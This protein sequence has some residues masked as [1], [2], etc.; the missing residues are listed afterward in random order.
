MAYGSLLASNMD[1]PLDRKSRGAFFTPRFLAE[2][3]AAWT[4]RSE[5]ERVLEPACGEAEFMLAALDRLVF[6]GANPE[7]AER[8]VDGVELH[9]ESACAA[10]RRLALSRYN[11]CVEVGDFLDRDAV[12]EYDAVIGNPPYIRF[13]AI[14]EAQRASIKRVSAR[15]GVK[16]SA[17][18][19]T[20]APFV[21]QSA[22]CLKKG[23]RLGL[24]LPA[25]LLSVNY[26]ASIRSFLLGSFSSIQLVTFD[27]LVFPEVQEEVVVL[28]ADGYRLG[29][30]DVIKWRQ[31]SDLT[32]LDLSSLVDYVPR[33]PED[34]WSGLF[35]SGN[36]LGYLQGLLDDGLFVPLEAWGRISLGVV[37]G[38]NGFFALS[39][40]QVSSYNL[41]EGDLVSL[42]PP[43]SRHLRRFDFSADDYDR[44]RRDNEKTKLFY[45]R[46]G[47]LSSTA[48]SYVETG[49]L[50][51]VH[52]A[53]KCRKR[54]PWWRVPVGKIPDAFVTYMN[55]YGPNICANSAGVIALNSCHGLF[56]SGESAGLGRELLPLACMNSATLFGSEIVG[57]SYGGGMLKLEP[58]EACRLPVPSLA[59]VA[60][61]A[62]KLRA[63]RPY[64]SQLMLRRDYD[65]V[66]GLVDA[67]L[68]SCLEGERGFAQMAS[69]CTM[70]RLRRKRRGGG[71]RDG[72]A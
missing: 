49:E 7:S 33:S 65:A 2:F 66:V 24:V 48:E 40:E 5:S 62:D 59:V 8:C 20:W 31:C 14:G 22:L 36:A 12:G 60:A 45:P 19:S 30:A 16:M 18:S 38:N 64:A 69:S 29:R 44:L 68:I 43:G 46:K 3:I 15:S 71:K 53:Y 11:C 26:A 10:K 35:A 61:A 6:L 56:F 54:D 21:V 37:T 23:G 25:E 27:E 50:Q 67:V 17:L 13:Q 72:N 52:R 47:V 41:D 34:R 1:S 32:D 63:V 4:V 28:L 51:G 42:C 9:A 55:S 57:R 39:E 58:K 70:M